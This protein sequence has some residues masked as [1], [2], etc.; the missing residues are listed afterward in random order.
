MRGPT[1]VV[2]FG[3]T[4]TYRNDALTPEVLA[5]IVNSM[6]LAASAATARK[7]TGDRIG[8]LIGALNRI[9]WTSSSLAEQS[10]APPPPVFVVC[11]AVPATPPTF[12]LTAYSVE[13]DGPTVRRSVLTL[14]EAV[15]DSAR[16]AIRAKLGAKALTP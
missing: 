13:G 4:V 6:Q 2:I 5:D 12:S 10:P 9:G 15:F 8:Q 7:E 3:D 1:T 16:A 14:N 11:Q